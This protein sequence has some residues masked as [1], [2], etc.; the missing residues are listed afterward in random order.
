MLDIRQGLEKIRPPTAP[1]AGCSVFLALQPMH[2]PGWLME[3]ICRVA[4]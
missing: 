3:S 1:G 4:K 2:S